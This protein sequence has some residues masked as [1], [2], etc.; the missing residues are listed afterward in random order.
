MQYPLSLAI[1]AALFI[2]YRASRPFI[3][4]WLVLVAAAVVTRMGSRT[5]IAL[6]LLSVTAMYHVLVR[7]L[8]LTLIAGA[9]AAGLLG[10]L[11]LGAL[12][13][14]HAIPNPFAAATEFE[15][16]LGNAVHLARLG[17]AIDDVPAGLYFAD[18]A[19]L[20]PQ[21]LLPFTKID[22]GA[23]YV[24]RFFPD[25]A[26]AGGGLAFGTIAEAVLTGGALSALL[27]GAALGLCFATV[28]RWYVHRARSFWA[29]VFYIWLMTLCYQSFR[30]TTFSLGVL[31]VYRF[32]PA[33]VMV[34]V[35][36]ALFTAAIRSRSAFASNAMAPAAN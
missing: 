7:P 19:A 2:S 11:V 34:T 33:V 10:F 8:S 1:L 4:V 14:G 29:F 20:V 31:I 9:A 21:Q 3:F 36:A 12:R 30:N 32:L 16:L 27:R 25:F 28:H 26:A 22:A 15:S 17:R 24:A 35:L 5:E 13:S 6:L 18:L 23:W